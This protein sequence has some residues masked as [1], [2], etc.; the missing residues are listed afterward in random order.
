[1]KELAIKAPTLLTTSGLLTNA[2]MIAV[3]LTECDTPAT[4]NAALNTACV[5]DFLWCYCC[6]TSRCQP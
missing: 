3:P 1:M 2:R 5:E 4:P 6:P